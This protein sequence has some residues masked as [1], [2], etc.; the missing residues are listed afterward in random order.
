MWISMQ[1]NTQKHFL[2]RR[3]NALLTYK[4]VVFSHTQLE[5]QLYNDRDYRI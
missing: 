4:I 3:L 5:L 2:I 1:G